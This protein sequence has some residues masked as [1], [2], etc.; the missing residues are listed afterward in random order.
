M[1]F[2]FV[3]NC[4]FL[5]YGPLVAAYSATNIKNGI[6]HFFGL[7]VRVLTIFVFSQVIKVGGI[8]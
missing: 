3:A 8:S 2:S 1:P 7:P 6:T 4:L 5:T